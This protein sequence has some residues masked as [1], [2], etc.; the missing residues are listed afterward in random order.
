MIYDAHRTAPPGT[1]VVELVGLRSTRVTF[2]RFNS[3]VHLLDYVFV[4]PGNYFC[5]LRR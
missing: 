3:F 4:V 5:P 2:V 1:Y